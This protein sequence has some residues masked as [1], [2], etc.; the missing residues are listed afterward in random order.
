MEIEYFM[1]I[2]ANSTQ[3]E[4]KRNDTRGEQKMQIYSMVDIYRYTY[5][6]YLHIYKFVFVSRG[7]CKIAISHIKLESQ[8]KS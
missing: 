5:T 4:N 7:C 8:V 3:L 2:F 1:R 6:T